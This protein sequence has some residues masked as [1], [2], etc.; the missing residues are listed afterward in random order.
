VDVT[1]GELHSTF[2]DKRVSTTI[3]HVYCVEKLRD[4]GHGMN[5]IDINPLMQC[6][7][8]NVNILDEF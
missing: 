1:E 2:E 7:W 4:E 8:Q 3:E 5:S 6:C